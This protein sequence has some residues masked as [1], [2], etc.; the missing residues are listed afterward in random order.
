MTYPGCSVFPNLNNPGNDTNNKPWLCDRFNHSF[1]E[2]A[3]KPSVKTVVISSYWE[4]FMGRRARK[5]TAGIKYGDPSSEKSLRSFETQIGEL[6]KSG[7][8]V[9]IILSNPIAQVEL[10]KPVPRRLAVFRKG[11]PRAYSTLE[12]QLGVTELASAHLRGIAARTGAKIIDPIP[13]LCTRDACPAMTV[14]GEPIYRDD[15]HL[16][17]GIIRRHA[18]WI[19]Q[20]FNR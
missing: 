4:A 18:T 7:K 15:K 11:S 5:H 10:T 16:R 9:Y 19:D 13:A 3:A 12:F 20:V 6:V 2:Y 1:F 8:T 14:E 17:A